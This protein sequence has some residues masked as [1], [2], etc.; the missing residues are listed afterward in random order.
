M[1]RVQQ[2]FQACMRFRVNFTKEPSNSHKNQARFLNHAILNHTT[3][4]PFKINMH[5]LF[6]QDVRGY[7]S[8]C[9]P[10]FH[11]PNH[12]NRK[13][14]NLSHAK[15]PEL[16]KPPRLKQSDTASPSSSRG[17]GLV[18]WHSAANNDRGVIGDI[19]IGLVGVNTHTLLAEKIHEHSARLV[20]LVGELR[21]EVLVLLHVLD[22]LVEQVGRV[23]RSA[24]GLGVELGAE[25]GSRVVNQTLVGLVVQVGE[26][27]PPLT[28]KSSGVN[29]VSMVL[30][31]DVAFASAQIES[32]DVV[33]TVAVLELDRLRASGEGNQLVTHANTHDR[34]L[35]RL[36]QL[37]EV[38][39]GLCAVSWVTRAVGDEDTIKVV[40][41][42][43]DG[44]VVREAGNAGSTRDKAAKDVLLDTTVDQ[45]NVHVAK[46]RA[47]VER[48]LG[49]DTTNQVDG[50]RV[51][52]GLVLVGI[53]LLANGDTSEGRT[54]LTEVCDDLTSVDTRDSGNTLTGAPLSKRLNSGPVAVLQS[55]VLNDDT[56]GLDVGGLE[57]T[58]QTVLI[59]GSRRHAVV[60]NQGLGKD[61]NLSTVGG[62]GH[63][64]GVSNEGGGKDGFTRDV[65]LGTKRLSGE[66]GAVL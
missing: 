33:G 46:R 12:T 59:T 13:L 64:L 30:R 65:G 58:Q 55:V 27:L 1:L 45:G 2:D 20:A 11:K 16:T 3:E 61:E 17:D 37:A 39:H 22:V 42:L 47:D 62:V 63:G 56:R 54:L 38:E 23:E 24:L 50:L 57:V 43:V 26:V 15:T 49:R 25:N 35:R 18:R 48:C 60:A 29:S 14:P 28:G 40:S 21:L 41:D 36:E 52:K 51:D 8:I 5:V 66:D 9:P 34:N 7:S 4:M 10:S 6:T 44:V 53:V 32:R 19:E 31:G